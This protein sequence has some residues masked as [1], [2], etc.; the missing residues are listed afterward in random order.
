MVRAVAGRSGS[1]ELMRLHDTAGLLVNLIALAAGLPGCLL[2]IDELGHALKGVKSC[3]HA[4]PQIHQNVALGCQWRIVADDDRRLGILGPLH[5]M[6]NKAALAKGPEQIIQL[7]SFL[8]RI[9]FKEQAMTL[10]VGLLDQFAG[11]DAADM[12]VMSWQNI[13]VDPGHAARSSRY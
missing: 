5:L 12:R 10:A 4:V 2:I 7:A 8:G 13:K 11:G 6:R 1:V 9:G 3:W